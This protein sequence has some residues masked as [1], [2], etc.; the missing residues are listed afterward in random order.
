MT[1]KVA[2]YGQ[3]KAFYGLALLVPLCF[4][5]AVGWEV[6]TRGR[7]VLQGALGALLLVWAM[8]SF[9]SFWIVRSAAQH[10]YAGLR[11]GAERKLEAATAEANGAVEADPSNATARRFLA[12]VLN[13]SGRATEAL[14]Q[15]QRAVELSPMDGAC[16]LQLGMV[17]ARQGQMEPAMSEARRALEL[18]PE[19]FSAY[20]FYWVAFRS[21]AGARRRSTLPV[22]DWLCLPL[23]PSCIK[24]SGLRWRRRKI[25]SRLPI[26]LSTPFCFGR[27][28]AQARSNFRLALRFIGKA[29]DG[30]KRLQEVALFA[31]D[32]PVILNE[33]AWFFATQADATLRNGPEAVRLA[34]QA[35]GLTGRTAPEMLATLAAAYAETDKV[36]QAIKIAEEARLRARSS[37]DADTV[38]LTE[39]LL[40]A[41]QAGHAYHEEPVQK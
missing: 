25:S 27:I 20:N 37:G 2:C 18:G 19:N 34:E 10:V 28:C 30:L 39:K 24:P 7:R 35:C 3:V 17:L 21:W 1:L 5:G 29:P 4:F 15:A 41:F 40:T 31:P 26:T 14:P 8:N 11:W 33:I 32:A 12:L 36:P 9:A 6:L 38:N 16:H 22:M 13:E 23:V